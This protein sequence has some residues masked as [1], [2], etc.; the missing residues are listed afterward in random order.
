MTLQNKRET[1]EMGWPD[2]LSERRE[3]NSYVNEDAGVLHR[4]A[5]E[6]EITGERDISNY[7]KPSCS[8]AILQYFGEADAA[9]GVCMAKG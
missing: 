5:W 9:K 6:L 7:G 8:R 2:T 4:Y 3:Y 1:L